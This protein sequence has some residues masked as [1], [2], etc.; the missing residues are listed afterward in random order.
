MTAESKRDEK[1]STQTSDVGHRPGGR[2][3]TGIPMMRR[4]PDL[5]QSDRRRPARLGDGGA[6]W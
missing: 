5:F 3:P 6:I 1:D 4:R 2:R